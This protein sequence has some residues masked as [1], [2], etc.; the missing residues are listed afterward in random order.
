MV[1]IFNSMRAL[2]L[3]LILIF[4]IAGQS[5]AQKPKKVK[6]KKT[7]P[8]PAGLFGM[9][10][11]SDS[12]R[13]FLFGGGN[14]SFEYTNSIFWYDSRI[15]QWLDLSSSQQI[16]RYRYGR[17]VYIED[18]Q[19]VFLAGGVADHGNQILNISD[20]IAFDVTNYKSQSLVQ[21]PLQSKYPGL[22][23][24]EGI[25]YFFG[26]AIR[27]NNISGQ[28]IF[29]DEFYSYDPSKGAI[30]KLSDIPEAKETGGGVIDGIL[31]VFG[32]Y[33]NEPSKLVHGYNIQSQTW[34]LVSQFEDPVS[35]YALVQ[36]EHYFILIGDYTDTDQ[37]LM[38]DT[39]DQTYKEYMMNINIRH[40]GAAIIKD[41][42][43]VLGG[44]DDVSQTVS[45]GHWTVPIQSILSE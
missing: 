10:Y 34:T 5:F 7:A 27:Y 17:A 20:L 38:Y 21:I 13:I 16:G 43:H 12:I 4:F 28:M 14:A 9:A 25:L 39:N 18:Y 24:S 3:N 1:D 33:H 22:A 42:L 30:K 44:V 31:Y 2:F 8:M 15:H 41:T 35:A 45:S 26:G 11:C 40:A 23:Q 6:F 29:T 19:S 32:G 36:Y 37:L